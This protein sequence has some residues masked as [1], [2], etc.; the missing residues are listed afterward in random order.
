MSKSDYLEKMNDIIGDS[1]K[2]KL[3]SSV[4]ELDNIDKVESEIIKFLI[5]LFTKNEFI[6][7]IFNLI[8]PVGL[9]TPRL[10]GLPKIHKENIPLRPILSMVNSEQHKLAK[11]L[12]LSLEPVLKHF[13]AYCLKDSFTFVDNIKEMEANNTFIVSFDV[14]SLF[15]NVLLEE[16]IEICVDIR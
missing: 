10:Y 12:D 6:E 16:V 9:V 1:T 13:L 5:Q 4:K 2:F 15:T 3:L 8:K 7:S 14:K 11:F